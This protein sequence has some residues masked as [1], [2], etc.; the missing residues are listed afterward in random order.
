[1]ILNGRRVDVLKA[2]DYIKRD[3]AKYVCKEY[4]PSRLDNEKFE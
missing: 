3:L 4:K 1:M 2:A